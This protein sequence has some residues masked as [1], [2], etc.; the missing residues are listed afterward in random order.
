M[1]AKMTLLIGLL[2]GSVKPDTTL[3]TK[4]LMKRDTVLADTSKTK[5][6]SEPKEPEAYMIQQVTYVSEFVKRFNNQITADGKPVPDS[7]RSRSPAV[8]KQVIN[9][10]FDRLGSAAISRTSFLRTHREQFLEQ[11]CD[12]HHPIDLTFLSEKLYASVQLQ[13][14]YQGK[15][16]PIIFYLKSAAAKQSY[17]WKIVDVQ[18]PFL[19]GKSSTKSQTQTPNDSLFI[20][21]NAQETAFLNLFNHIRDRHSLLGLAANP[22][23]PSPSLVMLSDMVSQ[24][25]ITP[26]HTDYPVVYLPMDKGWVIQLNFSNRKDENS[27]WLITDLY[28]VQGT[29]IKRLPTPFIPYISQNHTR[30]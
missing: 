23:N 15:E 3:P 10:L 14:A 29:D 8:R 19:T 17:V 11:V 4:P 18:A 9:Q 30:K 5:I 16:Q 24:G 2:N 12:D 13:A 27:G 21:L 1:L 22:E 25:Q 20:P 28:Q 6:R 7:L 26:I